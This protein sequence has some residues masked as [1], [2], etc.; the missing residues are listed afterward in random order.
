MPV[1]SRAGTGRYDT[2]SWR[3]QFLRVV[4]DT[5]GAHNNTS[6]CADTVDS[7][8]DDVDEDTDTQDE[9]TVQPADHGDD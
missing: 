9:Q 1:S 2:G 7:D 3:L 4:S 6:Q 5:V 8:V